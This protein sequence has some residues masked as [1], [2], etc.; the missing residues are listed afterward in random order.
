LAQAAGGA[1]PGQGFVAWPAARGR[2]LS[3]SV[4]MTITE[5]IHAAVLCIPESVW[6][7]AVESGGQVRDGAWGPN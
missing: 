2:W 6:T 5:Q 7:L 1:R 4:G 3:Y